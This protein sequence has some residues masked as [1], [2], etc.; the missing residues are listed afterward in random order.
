MAS[1]DCCPL[2]LGTGDRAGC[3]LPCGH[4][5]CFSCMVSCIALKPECPVCRSAVTASWQ[6]LQ[7]DEVEEPPGGAA[8]AA[9][10]S[11]VARQP[12]HLYAGFVGGLPC[13]SWGFIFRQ[14]PA[15]L[16]LLQPWLREELRQLL[17][18]EHPRVLALEGRILSS[19]P[20]VG[21]HAEHLAG[22]LQ[23]EL[24]S[25]TGPF[26]QQLIGFTVERC[27]R[28]ALVLLGGSRQ[29]MQQLEQVPGQDVCAA[30]FSRWQ[31]RGPVAGASWAACRGSWEGSLVGSAGPGGCQE[32]GQE[33]PRASSCAPAPRGAR[34]GQR[35]A[36][37]SAAACAEGTAAA[38]AAPSDSPAPLPAGHGPG[39]SGTAPRGRPSCA[40]PAPAPA[41]SPRRQGALLPAAEEAAAALAGAG[42]GRQCPWAGCGCPAPG[43]AGSLPPSAWAFCFR[44]RPDLLRLLRPWLRWQLRR[45]PGPERCGLEESIL[46]ALP[47]LGLQE[48]QLR[49]LLRPALRGRT[50]RFV[51]QLLGF[52]AARL[53]SRARQL[54]RRGHC[55]LARSLQESPAEAICLGLFGTRPRQSPLPGQRQQGGSAVPEGTPAPAP[56]SA[57]SAAQGH[58]GCPCSVPAPVPGQQGELLP[59][60]QQAAG[61]ASAPGQG[62]ES[63]CQGPRQPLKRKAT[64]SEG[65]AVPPKKQCPQ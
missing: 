32:P 45:M 13:S 57:S 22:L 2:C 31:D 63:S 59:Q 60:Q 26:V 36:S 16:R 64:G 53:G 25:R 52:A 7:G 61:G 50:A 65:S 8:A 35:A 42:P 21:L 5:F 39:T 12:W 48:Q 62:K 9:V 43:P 30:V 19:L 15:L 34:Q 24:Q 49:R 20:A 44:V 41:A 40:H 46:S 56:A 14:R 6:L 11:A 33:E 17:G 1:G 29:A 3:A 54:L 4:R 37:S 18:A 10:G 55:Q 23:A 38:A 47:V 27:R 28:A 51:Q 58:P